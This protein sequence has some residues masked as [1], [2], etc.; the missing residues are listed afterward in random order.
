MGVRVLH[1]VTAFPRSPH[2]VIAP[3]LVELLKRLRA[4]GI[5][6]EVLTSAYRGGGNTEFEGI[7]VHRFRYF[8]RGWEDL[9][10][11]EAV[12][13]RM[14]RSW[15]YKLAAVSYVLAGM[16]AARRLARRR[17][18]DLVHVHWAMP[19]AL[20]G[21]AAR[22]ACG[23]KIVT[24]F[25]GVELRWTRSALRPLG[26][27]L[28]RAAQTSDKIVAISQHT[29]DDVRRLAGVEAEVIPYGIGLPSPAA[30]TSPAAAAAPAAGPFTV[31]FVGRLVERKGVHVLLDAAAQLDQRQAVR[32]VIVGDGPERAALE[33]RASQLGLKT[34]VEFR[35]W[36]SAA[37][38][39][40]AYAS[41]RV[42]VLPAI[43]D[44]RGDTEG[45]GVVLLEAMSYGIPVVASD[46]GGITDIVTNGE[47]GLLVPPGDATALK[48]AILQLHRNPALAAQLGAAGARRVRNQFSWDV[49]VAR[50]EELY[51]SLAVRQHERV[52]A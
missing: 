35:G 20:F 39:A 37:E 2:D 4:R 38:L 25:Y 24:T 17:R 12:P 11:D 34:V 14:R 36:V 3:W 18:Y 31:L 51:R 52:E 42:C 13:D 46:T 40:R 48:T 22:A 32:I 9:T 6:V 26:R 19:H 8:P 10:H 7:P 47:T 29:A 41:A 21:W 43:V 50:W 27:I 44:R 5:E 1:V 28:V 49:I 33:A 45:L 16:R 23:A 15:R 30:S